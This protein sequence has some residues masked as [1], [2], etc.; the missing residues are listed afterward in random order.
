VLCCFQRG[1]ALNAKIGNDRR[2]PASL[3]DVFLCLAAGQ[4]SFDN[5]Q[6]LGREAILGTQRDDRAAAVQDV[7][8]QLERRGMHQAGG[9]NAQCNVVN[10]LTAMHRFGNHQLFVFAPLKASGDIDGSGRR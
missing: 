3:R 4:R 2:D 6:R 5:L 1:S 7:A 8:N 10:S 9:V